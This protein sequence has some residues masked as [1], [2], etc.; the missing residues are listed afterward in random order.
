MRWRISF[1]FALSLAVT[2]PAAA[3]FPDVPSKTTQPYVECLDAKAKTQTLVGSYHGGWALYGYDAASAGIVLTSKFSDKIVFPSKL[4]ETDTAWQGTVADAMVFEV[5]GNPHNPLLNVTFVEGFLKG[6]GP[7]DAQGCVQSGPHFTVSRGV[8]TVYTEL[9]ADVAI[10][11]AVVTDAELQRYGFVPEQVVAGS[12]LAK[13]RKSLVGGLV[14][15]VETI[16]SLKYHVTIASNTS[17]APTSIEFTAMKGMHIRDTITFPCP[18][19]SPSP[20]PT[21]VPTQ[22]PCDENKQIT[23]LQEQ[24]SAA[25]RQT[26]QAEK[27]TAD[28][29]LSLIVVSAFAGVLFTALICTCVYKKKHKRELEFGSLGEWVTPLQ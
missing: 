25:K 13:T 29:R 27:E 7:P 22:P 28:W 21:P 11:E 3:A 16:V 18:S 17:S 2:V 9:N 10:W 4:E 15:H 24:I 23:E 6:K 12:A 20:T 8:T 14:D 1:I 26:D 19:T 5:G